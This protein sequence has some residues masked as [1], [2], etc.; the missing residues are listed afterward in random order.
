MASQLAIELTLETVAESMIATFSAAVPQT[1]SPTTGGY[2]NLPAAL[3]YAVH[4]VNLIPEILE[5]DACKSRS[6]TCS[7]RYCFYSRIAEWRSST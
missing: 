7:I 3:N 1:P 4:N 6:V 5:F 2:I